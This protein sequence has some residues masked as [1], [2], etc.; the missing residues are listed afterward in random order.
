MGIKYIC[1][2]YW[3]CYKLEEENGI[4]FIDLYN[5]YNDVIRMI[6][7]IKDIIII[8]WYIECCWVYCSLGNVE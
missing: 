1:T 6:Y 7:F 8:I 3:E 4:E 2:E 5:N